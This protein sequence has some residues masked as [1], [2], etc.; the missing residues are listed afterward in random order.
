MEIG[1]VQLTKSIKSE[2]A[3]IRGTAHSYEKIKGLPSLLS[4]PDIRL[5]GNLH[6][7]IVLLKLL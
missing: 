3:N 7:Y 2:Q 1:R 4:I 5:S 6:C